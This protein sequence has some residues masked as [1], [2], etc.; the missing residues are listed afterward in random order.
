MIIDAK[1]LAPHVLREAAA[2]Y[3][4]RGY[5]RLTGLED[6][7]TA[8]FQDI[9][10]RQLGVD[11]AGMAAILESEGLSYD[12]TSEE[13]AAVSRIETDPELAGSLLDA[14]GPL[15]NA[16]IGPVLHV[17]ST[18]H[19]QF[20][21]GDNAG[22]RV[23]G[24]IEDHM[25]VQRPYL[26]HQDFA[27][28]RIP[29]SPCGVTLWVGINTTPDWKLR[30]YPGTHTLGLLCQEWMELTDERLA[31]FGEPLDLPGTRGDAV[32]FNALLL[33]GTGDKGPCRRVSCDIRFFPLC[34]W[35]PSKFHTLTD[36]P[37]EELRAARAAKADET[38]RAP[39]LEVGAYLG[40]EGGI[41]E[42]PPRS[43]LNWAA[44]VRAL[45]EG[46]IAGSESHIARFVNEE[47]GIDPPATYIDRF[48]GRPF[49]QDT[50][51]RARRLLT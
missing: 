33:H 4:E 10:T 27:G 21:G 15:L 2:H 35:L 25:E 50:I 43:I 29:T 39:L 20:K 42:A 14:V 13:R 6:S 19:G 41:D 12:F 18:F 31:A 7:V 1:N 22:V 49:V 38:L 26:L 30:L 46:R 34:G 9:L 44:Y 40:E 24:G 51:D 3:S 17:S 45:M 8:P 23:G 11:E 28:A 32:V 16:L 47:V 36:R 5:V 37:L 48:H